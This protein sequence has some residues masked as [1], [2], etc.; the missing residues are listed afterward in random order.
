MTANLPVVDPTKVTS[1]VIILRG[2]YDGIAALPDL[3]AF[4]ARLP[5]AD[6]Q[7]AILPGAAHA[8]SLGR[9][10]DQLWHVLR[11]FLDMPPRHDV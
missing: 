4:F 1:P 7:F 3:L 9:N 6:R 11:A 10:R 2:E 5:S 8:V